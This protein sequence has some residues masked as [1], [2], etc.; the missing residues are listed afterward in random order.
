MLRRGVYTYEYRDDWKK[1]NET[2]LYEK[3]DFHLSMEDITDA[4]QT[5]PKRVCKSLEIKNLGEYHDLCVQRDTFE[6]LICILIIV[7]I[8]SKYLN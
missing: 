3:E 5:H 8:V 1:F 4:D 7:Q 6:N 2:F